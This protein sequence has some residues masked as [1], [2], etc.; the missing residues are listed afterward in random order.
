MRSFRGR[1]GG[2]LYTTVTLSRIR[3]D[4][5]GL[6]GGGGG[7][8][9][10]GG[11]EEALRGRRREVKVLKGRVDSP[12]QGSTFTSPSLIPR[13]TTRHAFCD[14]QKIQKRGER[15]TEA[16]GGKKRKKKRGKKK[17]SSDKVVHVRGQDVR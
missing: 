5:G 11:Q 9:I 3:D 2:R 17:R 13:T 10:E 14:L 4:M 15:R 6:R 16:I 7:E 1:G 8:E 12:L